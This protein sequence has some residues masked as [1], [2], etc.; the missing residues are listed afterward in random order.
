MPL[1]IPQVYPHIG[2]HV[3]HKVLESN[4]MEINSLYSTIHYVA[5]A[6]L[7][8]LIIKAHYCANYNLIL[9]AFQI[10]HTVY[11]YTYMSG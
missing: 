5:A 8:S 3:M 1:L 11:N 10:A 4:T 9:L 6:V 2:I 7:K